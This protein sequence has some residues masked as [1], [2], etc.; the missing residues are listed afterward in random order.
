VSLSAPALLDPELVRPP[1][2][3]PDDWPPPTVDVTVII[4]AYNEAGTI[5]ET[6][7][8]I[9]RQTVQPRG[10]IVVDDCSSDGTGDRARALGATVIRPPTNT[11]SKAG[12]QNAA[13]LHVRSDF[14][15]AVDA[16]TVL[17]DDGIERLLAAIDNKNVAS[18]C[19]FV[20][21]R[22]IRSIWERGRYVEYLF[23][24]GFYKRTQAS[25]P[26]DR[27]R[28][29]PRRP[30]SLSRR[31]ARVAGSGHQDRSLLRAPAAPAV[32]RRRRGRHPRQRRR[33]V[34]AR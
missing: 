27:S 21:P 7:R 24:F 4:P 25:P 12:A 34:R 19:G 18:A 2:A 20:V 23:G 1:R 33:A 9:Q 3:L 15:L 29:E 8:S 16:D 30:P 11:G 5:A 13:L 31:S 10:V 28:S 22:R 6:I 32:G 17:A 26:L 14:T